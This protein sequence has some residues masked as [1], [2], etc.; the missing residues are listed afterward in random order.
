MVL[1]NVELKFCHIQKPDENGKYS[2]AFFCSNKDQEAA[3]INLIDETWENDKGSFTKE[4]K[5]LGYKTYEN[6]DDDNDPHNG[7][8]IF[9]CS[10]N[11]A[12]ADGQYEF[13]VD[14]YDSS[15]KLIDKEAVP[16]IGWGTKGDISVSTYCWTYQK[17]K[18]VKLNFDAFRIIDLVEREAANPFANA[19]EVEGGYEAPTNPFNQPV[20]DGL[21]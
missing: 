19:A 6:P 13:K 5:S 7:D 16:N 10:Q 8:T 1:T 15:K 3:L 2:T 9:N 18:G 11:A 21:D 14:V 20:V 4:P 12:S 17:A